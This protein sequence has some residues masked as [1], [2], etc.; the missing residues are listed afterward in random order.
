MERDP[1][2]GTSKG[3]GFVSCTDFES[4]DA[5]IESMNGQ[6]L[7]NKDMPSKMAGRANDTAH[8]LNVF[9]LLKHVRTMHSLPVHVLLAHRLV[10]YPFRD[11]LKANFQERSPNRLP[12]PDLHPSRPSPLGLGLA[13]PP[14]PYTCFQPYRCTLC[15]STPT[16]RLWPSRYDLSCIQPGMMPP[17]PPFPPNVM[18][19]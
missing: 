15:S 19:R 9:W 18:G 7:M 12:H 14:P 17:A 3:Y 4:S 11:H 13:P 5:A 8:R 2:T 10:F 6:Y 16:S 1:T